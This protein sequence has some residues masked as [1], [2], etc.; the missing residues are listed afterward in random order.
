MIYLLDTNVISELIKPIPDAN[1]IEWI[2]YV[3]TEH[4]AISVLTIGEIRKGIEK[5]INPTRKA[6][7]IRWLEID[8]AEWFGARVIP[9]NSDVAD[10]WGYICGQSSKTLPAIDGLLAASALVY[11]MKIVT[12]N[13]KDFESVE[14]LELVNPWDDIDYK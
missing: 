9:V 11:N 2:Q 13:V 4:L 3:Q 1:V 6:G 10:K 5:T 7:L 14:G 12:R 8:L